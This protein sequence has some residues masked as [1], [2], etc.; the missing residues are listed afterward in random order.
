MSEIAEAFVLALELIFTGDHTVL[1]IAARS[2]EIAGSS[3][4]FGT[5]IF[6]PLGCLIHFREFR[7]KGFLITT[8]QTFYSLPT[9]FVGLLVFLT[10]SR[11]GPLGTF[12]TLFSPP[13]I[14]VGEVILIAPILTGLTISALRGLGPEI[15]DTAVSL[16]ATR[17]QTV[18]IMLTEAKFALLTA[19]LLG[20]GRAISEVG[21]ALMVGGNISGYTRTMPTAMS[22]YTQQGQSADAIALGLILISIVL[23]ISIIANILQQR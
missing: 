6:V 10:F 7:G 5:L 23:V 14:I 21:V 4:F 3:I 20:F 1:S 8:I 18:R 16:G 17:I 2:M 13:A 9:V 22:L 19:I 12:G 11:V 15:K